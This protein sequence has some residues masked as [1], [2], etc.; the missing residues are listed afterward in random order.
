MPN[1][2]MIRSTCSLYMM[3][4][5]LKRIIRLHLWIGYTKKHRNRDAFS[6]FLSCAK[7]CKRNPLDSPPFRKNLCGVVT[8]FSKANYEWIDKNVT[9]ISRCLQNVNKSHKKPQ[10]RGNSFLRRKVFGLWN[11]K[12]KVSPIYNMNVQHHQ[13]Y[14]QFIK[15]ADLSD[16]PQFLSWQTPANPV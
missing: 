10:E 9:K 13:H 4:I 16:K 6:F 1:L 5:Y 14:K 2:V 3:L 12:G 7:S 8:H 15:R 11:I